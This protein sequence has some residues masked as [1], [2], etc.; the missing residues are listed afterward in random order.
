MNKEPGDK[1]TVESA[2]WRVSIE[3]TDVL[4]GNFE[5]L[6]Q[7]LR[8]ACVGVGFSQQTVDECLPGH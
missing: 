7:A 4:N 8:Q 2:A 6:Y 5:E 1:C 3:N